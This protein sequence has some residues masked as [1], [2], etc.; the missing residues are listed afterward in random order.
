M[1]YSC[2]HG[3]NITIIDLPL[4]KQVPELLVLGHTPPLGTCR[5]FLDDLNSGQ[6]LVSCNDGIDGPPEGGLGQEEAQG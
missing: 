3:I 5:I 2:C 1:A 6:D 4:G